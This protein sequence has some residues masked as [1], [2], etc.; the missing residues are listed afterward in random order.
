LLALADRETKRPDRY[1]LP[2]LAALSGA[3]IGEVAQLWGS[4]VVRADGICAL[5]IAL[6]ADGGSRKNEVSERRVPIH[7]AL[8]EH[9]FLD[10]ARSKGGGPLFYGRGRKGVSPLPR[11]RTKRTRRTEAGGMKRS[12]MV[13]RR[14]ASGT[15]RRAS[16]TIWRPGSRRTG[17]QTS[18][19]APNHA[20]R[21]WFENAC[22]RA[23]VLD[24]V[25]DQIQGHS[26]QRGEADRDR[27]ADI[28]AMYHAIRRIPVPRVRAEQVD[29]YTP[30]R[31]T[32][33]KAPRGKPV[34]TRWAASWTAPLPT[35]PGK[36][37]PL[38]VPTDSENRD[39]RSRTPSALGAEANLSGMQVTSTASTRRR[40]WLL[41]PDQ[42]SAPQIHRSALPPTP[43]LLTTA[44]GLHDPSKMP[45]LPQYARM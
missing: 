26:G 24:S 23:G 5:Q 10:F 40:R 18:A 42:T 30:P 7:P 3:R 17:S 34:V 25:A 31:R 20:L 38:A 14:L 37:Q 13:T 22:T 1:W 32:A 33:L 35:P 45:S 44:G 12:H 19:K 39:K 16:R 15:R 27:H 4:H 2:W 6:A 21:R 43:S 29:Q 8:I 36:S 41:L 11:L 9:G 28:A